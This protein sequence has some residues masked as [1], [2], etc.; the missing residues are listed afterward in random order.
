VLAA[1]NQYVGGSSWFIGAQ[2]GGL[3]TFGQ[4]VSTDYRIGANSPTSDSRSSVSSASH[5]YLLFSS[6]ELRAGKGRVRDVTGVHLAQLTEQRLRATGRLER[7]L[8]P[9]TRQKL[10]ELFYLSGGF[11]AAHERADKHFWSEVERL[12]REDGALQDGSLDAYSLFRILEPAM[13][14]FSW[15]RRR[16]LAVSAVTSAQLNRG[17]RD[18]DNR[19]ELVDVSNGVISP[20]F[21][22]QLSARSRLKENFALSGLDL[23][24][25]MPL[26]EA[27]QLA[28]NSRV[29]YG[30]GSERIWNMSSSAGLTWLLADRWYAQGI[31]RYLLDSRRTDGARREP[32]WNVEST[33]ALGYWIEDA[34]AVEC[35]LASEQQTRRFPSFLGADSRHLRTHRLQLAL[36]YRPAGRFDAPSLGISEHL[37]PGLH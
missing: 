18:Q 3:L 17:H 31:A 29:R 13:Y 26:N 28:A 1:R 36:T 8:T 34:W 5:D 15:N 11:R 25:G 24:Y 30:G 7:E 22:F 9:A 27:W 35:A 6:L 14:R 32:D 23:D 37:T 10:A 20:V 12:L 21:G 16:G 33:A 19:S 4:A 2:L